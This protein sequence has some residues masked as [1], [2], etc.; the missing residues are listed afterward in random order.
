MAHKALG[1][2]VTDRAPQAIGPYSQAVVVDGMVYTAGCSRTWVRSS[3]R[4]APDST[5]S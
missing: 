1:I 2:V 3:R 4:Q 5:W